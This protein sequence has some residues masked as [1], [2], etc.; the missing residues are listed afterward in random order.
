MSYAIEWCLCFMLEYLW[1]IYYSTMQRMQKQGRPLNRD[2]FFTRNDVRNMER[3]IHNSSLE[4]LG[5]D[6]WSVKI[7]IQRHR[8][9]VFYFQDNSSSESFILG[10]QTDWQLQQML[11]Y[12]N[13][14]FISF[15]S[16]FGLKKLK[17]LYF[18]LFKQENICLSFSRIWSPY[19]PKGLYI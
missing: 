1:T 2:D 9:D 7:W 6:A 3:T 12:W 11:R 4:V 17:V 10:I 18:H 8:K 16:T 13:N 5:N 14:S 19:W 15:H